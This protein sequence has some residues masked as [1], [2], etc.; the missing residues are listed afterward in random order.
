VTRLDTF[1]HTHTIDS[2]ELARLAKVS[3]PYLVRLR[4]GRSEPSKAVMVRLAKACSWITCEKVY[5]WDLF[6]RV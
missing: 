1:I 4:N 2:E 3:G 5:A 6:D